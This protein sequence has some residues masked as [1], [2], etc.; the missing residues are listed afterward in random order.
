MGDYHDP[1]DEVACWPWIVSV[2][3]TLLTARETRV[4]AEPAASTQPRPT[5]KLPC[6][7]PIGTTRGL[8]S[9]SAES[10]HSESGTCPS[11][12]PG[13]RGYSLTHPHAHIV[14]YRGVIFGGLQ[15][16]G[17]MRTCEGRGKETPGELSAGI[18]AG[19]GKGTR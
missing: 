14:Q 15:F 7:L 11:S 4:V 8:C 10:A 5:R 13:R 1:S 3:P 16:Q 17:G 18:G 9:H 6:L 2:L 19:T 12:V